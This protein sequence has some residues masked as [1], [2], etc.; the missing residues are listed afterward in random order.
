MTHYLHAAKQTMKLLFV[1][2]NIIA[3]IHNILP[4][5]HERVEA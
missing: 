2:D 5:S 3:D 1:N 4:S